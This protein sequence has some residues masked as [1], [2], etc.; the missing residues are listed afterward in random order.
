MKM[1][2]H[3]TSEIDS[4]E[5]ERQEM[6]KE[7]I[8]DVRKG[9]VYFDEGPAWGRVRE[10]AFRQFVRGVGRALAWCA[11]GG[12]RALARVVRARQVLASGRAVLRRRQAVE[13]P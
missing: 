2:S 12:C 4:L 8:G 7:L 5:H 3:R 6:L 9:R 11:R 10:I 1:T 13:A